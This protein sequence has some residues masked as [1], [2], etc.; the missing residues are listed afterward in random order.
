MAF[1]WVV[2]GKQLYVFNAFFMSMRAGFTAPG[3]CIHYFTVSSPDPSLPERLLKLRRVCHV[4]K[5]LRKHKASR[6]EV[7]KLTIWL[8]DNF[9]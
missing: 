5:K 7:F 2:Q 1:F 9:V 8:R 4:L 3:K 6:K